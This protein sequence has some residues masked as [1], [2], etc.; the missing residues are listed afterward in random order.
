MLKTPRLLQC[1]RQARGQ[2]SVLRA[3]L[4][5][6]FSGLASKPPT[7]IGTIQER[8]FTTER[9][10]ATKPAQLSR[11]WRRQTRHNSSNA[12]SKE[13]GAQEPQ[14][15]S[16]R[17][18][19]MSRK[20]GW[21]VVGI[22]LGLSA[23]DFPFCFLAVRW[24]G[25]E[26][27]AAAEH[28]IVSRFW[29]ALESVV[30]SL[31]ERRAKNEEAEQA[32]KEASDAVQ[33]DAKHEPASEYSYIQIEDVQVADTDRIARY[34]DAAPPRVWSAQ[35]PLFPPSSSHISCHAQGGEDA[36]RLGVSDWKAKAE[37][38]VRDIGK[39]DKTVE[40]RW[41]CL[42]MEQSSTPEDGNV[43]T[44]YRYDVAALW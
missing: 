24:L 38:I 11:A 31:K 4:R 3:S 22:Y 33:T 17:M 14:S 19:A 13:A 20:Y 18:K 37:I 21:T 9:L 27:I 28:A 23:I 41:K 44:M 7:K 12:S 30:P 2:E 35:V 43:A 6:D 36:A 42:T 5:R 40:H 16:D 25:T 1:L 34:L 15:L 26:R 32:V 29:A 8:A 10:R 39:H